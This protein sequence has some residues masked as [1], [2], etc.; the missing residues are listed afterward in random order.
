MSIVVGMRRSILL[1]TD[2]S[3]PA[4]N[5]YSHAAAL[6]S[7]LRI[8][9]ILLHVVKAPPE[10]ETWSPA[11]RRKLGPMKTKALLELG[12]MA[13]LAKDHGVKAEHRLVVGIP[14]DAIL[15]I[16]EKT[17]ANLIAIGTHGRTGFERLRLGSV[18]EE[19][20]RKASSPVLTVHAASVADAPFRRQRPK[21]DTI[22]VAMDFSVSSDAALRTAAV[23]AARVHAQISLLHVFDAWA[24]VGQDDA[25]VRKFKSHKVDQ[26]A[27]RVLSTLRATPQA[28]NGIVVPGEAVKV[29]LDQAKSMKADVI[30]IGTN[31]RRGLKRLVL[32]SVAEA[33]VRRARCPVLVVKAASEP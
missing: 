3:K 22:L 19:V 23:L 20:L 32:G 9:L 4:R 15:D 24:S 7:L 16:A 11:A 13:R 6:A 14:E 31:G 2:F 5:A 8:R 25:R 28:F 27:Q 18:A 1:A 29:I 12:R 21:L 17:R 10:F 33:V 30:V 26:R